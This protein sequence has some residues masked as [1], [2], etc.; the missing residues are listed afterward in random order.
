MATERVTLRDEL[1]KPIKGY[2]DYF[3][4]NY[5]KVMSLKKG[6]SKVLL[7]QL[8]KCG[9]LS[10][11][12]YNKKGWRIFKV[13]RLIAVAFVDNPENKPTVNHI[14]GVKTNNVVENLEWATYSEQTNHAYKNHLYIPNYGED[15]HM[16]KFSQ[17]E[18]D[19]IK[20][21][22]ETGLYTQK[23]LAEKYGVCRRTILR[24]V[25]KQTY[26]EVLHV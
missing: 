14:D 2:K 13:H 16:A 22:Y 8:E 6:G 9:Y 24:M 17:L 21:L 10:V 12:L 18:A 7:Q 19:Q 5:G 20:R 11:R 1:W 3:V 25:N 15:H 26:G 23:E 4:S